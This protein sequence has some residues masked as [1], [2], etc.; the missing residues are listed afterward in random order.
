[1]KKWKLI[2]NFLLLFSALSVLHASHS[3]RRAAAN[4]LGKPATIKVLLSK[5]SDGALLEAH[6][7]FEVINPENKKRLS[8]GRKGKRF[9]LHPHK[10][11]IKWGETFLGIFQIQIVPTSA[12]TTFLVDGV[13]YRGSLEIY[14]IENQLSIINEV[15]VESFLKTTLPEKVTASFPSSV[16]DSIAI[17]ARTDAYYKALLNHGAFWHVKAS[18][19]CYF[20][21][22]LSHLNIE[23]DRAIDNTR[24]LVMTFEEQPFPATWTEHCAGKTANYQNIFRKNTPTPSG[25]ESIFAERD[26]A[27]ARWTFSIDNQ[28]L[29]KIAKINRVTGIDLFVD[30]QSNKV[31]AIRI[32]DGVHTE[33]IDFATFQD[34][35]GKDKLRSNDFAVSIKGNV[36]T[37]EGFGEGTGVGL[38]LFSAKNMSERGDNAPEILA[39]FF[40]YTHLEKMRCYPKAIVTENKDS[41][42]SPKQKSATERKYK[43]LHK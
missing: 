14:N 13:Q 35:L 20:G 15:D 7:S 24:H 17:I 32:H 36:A 6:G 10:E 34:Y 33:D 2:V 28:E 8:S 19:V 25:V 3:E 27:D 22:G 41:F 43:I 29:A 1:M 16:L 30:H 39:E 9:F 38:C 18:D 12:D 42:V 26:R 21:S 31:Y 40:P 37:F 5:D 4:D 23:M 11:G